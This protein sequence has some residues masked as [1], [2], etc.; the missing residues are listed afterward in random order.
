MKMKRTLAAGLFLALSAGPLAADEERPVVELKRLTL[1]TALAI[2]QG[3]IAACREQGV[4]VAV[5]VVDRNGVIQAQLRD[6]VSPPIAVTISRQK[7]FTAANFGAAT[8]ELGRLA[9]GPIGRVDG[10]TMSAGGLLI[11]A[12]GQ[13]LGGVGVSGAPSGETDEACA[14][15]G[16][17]VVRDDLEMMLM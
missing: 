6:T 9:D 13:F 11:E 17:D 12:G 10:V 16:I 8:S 1:E 15:A 2:A 3:A 4:S 7:A 5:A 14:K